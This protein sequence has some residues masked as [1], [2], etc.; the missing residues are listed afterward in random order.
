MA[1][2]ASLGGAISV[3]GDAD[4]YALEVRG[5]QTIR[6]D[7]LARGFRA[8]ATPGSD[9]SAVISILDPDGITILAQA[10]SQGQ[11]DDPAVSHQAAGDGVYFVSVENDDPS[12]GGPTYVYVLS[13]ELEE[14]GSFASAT[15]LEPPEVPSIDAL[16]FPAGDVDF[17]RIQ[18]AGGDLLTVDLDSAVFNPP[19]PPA[20]L[21]ASVYDPNFVLIAQDAYSAS[22]PADPYIQVALAGPGRHYIS[23][24]ELRVFVG[25]TNT[26][27]QMSVS[28][29]PAVDD[30]S[31]ATA[32]PVS[33]P[34]S[35]SAVSSPGTDIDHFG[36]A[37]NGSL[38]LAADVDAAEDLLSLL[39]GTVSIHTQAGVVA[40]DS[41]APDPLVTAA[42]GPGAYSVS[43][44]GGCAGSGCVSEDAYFVVHIDADADGD[45]LL[46][47]RDNCPADDNAG[48]QDG[49]GDAIGDLC[50]NC[51]VDFNPGQAD[52]N[53]DGLGDACDTC[54]PPAEVGTDMVFMDAAT[55]VWT[56]DPLVPFYDLY[57]GDLGAAGW[58]YDH[59]CLYAA[60]TETRAT[61]SETPA[62]DGAYYLL[63]G[64][65]ACGGTGV[66]AGSSGPRPL[67]SPCP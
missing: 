8:T 16:I 49:D 30:G 65:G 42:A 11:F 25:T 10:A 24:R 47:P 32:L 19:Q 61:D 57:R 12:L 26:Y 9:L 15:P 55:L 29:G 18:A 43:V 6:A 27:Y 2:P 39:D 64:R 17:Y 3:P 50:D 66:G 13:L 67:A 21:V 7:I 37:L 51:P 59:I 53:G 60:L 28:L 20:K 44:G 1:P 22:D 58:T 33:I 35:A 31:F 54:T 4:L 5:G 52:A 23:V 34:R 62:G 63:A 46:L 38:M 56:G 40:S 36:F 41:S 14:N 45:G 48:Q